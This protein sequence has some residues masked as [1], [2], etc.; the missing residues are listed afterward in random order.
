M[1]PSC[2]AKDASPYFSRFICNNLPDQE[3]DGEDILEP[4]ALRPMPLTPGAVLLAQ[5]T[6]TDASVWSLVGPLQHR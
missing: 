4:T 5:L 2:F 1:P 6:I 3:V